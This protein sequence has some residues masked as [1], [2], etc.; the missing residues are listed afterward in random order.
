[1]TFYEVIGLVSAC[2]LSAAFGFLAGRHEQIK[3]EDENWRQR[4]K[5]L[6]KA[7]LENLKHKPLWECREVK[8]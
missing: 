7:I 5:M 8:K 3:Y 4:E 1:M 2:L 6:T